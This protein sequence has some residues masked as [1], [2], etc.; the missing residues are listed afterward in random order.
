MPHAPT[1][2]IGLLGGV[3]SG[4]SAVARV[5]AELGAETL[6]ADA[7]AHR[8]LDEPD[9]Q[10]RIRRAWGDDVFEGGR[11][12][13]A[14]LAE[15][16]F[17]RRGEIEKLNA[18]VHPRVVE[19]LRGRIRAARERGAPAVVLDA[20]LLLEAGMAD[21]CDA[22]VFVD[23]PDERRRRFAAEQ[24]GWPP[25][26]AARREARQIPLDEKRRRADFV[27]H[28]TGSL[29]DLRE[30]ARALWRELTGGPERKP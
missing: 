30:Q 7:E 1:K 23:T 3:A 21:D 25:E 15:R 10:E 5:F 18:I 11:V 20:P 19:R 28:N 12:G 27:L 4:K 17:R 22:L 13:R 6:D 8:V 29:D 2:V 9:V 14:R 26:E 16:V 24:R